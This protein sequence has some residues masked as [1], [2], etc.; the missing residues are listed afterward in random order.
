MVIATLPGVEMEGHSSTCSSS[1][2]SRT[3]SRWIW[4]GV[5]V[6]IVVVLIT[7]LSVGGYGGA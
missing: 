1:G 4:R 3:I 7:E 6:L 2:N 5:V